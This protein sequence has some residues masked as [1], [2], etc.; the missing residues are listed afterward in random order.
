M[1]DLPSHK[2]QKSPNLLLKRRTERAE[3][4]LQA[5]IKIS[6]T[7]ALTHDKKQLLKLIMDTVTDLM[8][9]DRST[10]FL[11]DHENQEIVSQVIQG[12][13]SVH[14]R[15]PIGQ[16]VA[17]WVAQTGETVNLIDAY[18]DPRFHVKVDQKTG[19]TTRSILTMPL[20][21]LQ[22]H[23]IA[24]IQVLNKSSG[25][26]FSEEDEQLLEA[27]S[28]QAAIFLEN[29][30]LYS[31]LLQ[32][33]RELSDT[34][35]A[36]QQRNYELDILFSIEQQMSGAFEL[37]EMLSNILQRSTELLHCE[38]GLIGLIDKDKQLRLH[39][40]QAEK[41]NELKGRVLKQSEGFMGW[42]A[43][44]GQHI[45]SNNPIEDN[46]FKADFAHQ[47]GLSVRGVLCVPLL[48]G[49]TAIGAIE[50][51]NKR[52]G[53]E[54]FGD[55]DLRILSLIAARVS[56]A[57]IIGLERNKRMRQSRLATIG[58]LLSGVVH[59]FKTPMTLIAGYAQLT[60]NQEDPEKRKTFA[61]MIQ[62]Q[63]DRLNHMT[64]EVL[65]F[66]R[67]ESTLLVRKVHLNQFAQE[68]KQHLE[69]EFAHVP[70]QLEFQTS[71]TGD[72]YFDESKIERLLH[73]LARNA[74]QAMPNGGTFA[75]RIQLEDEQLVIYAQDTGVGIPLE[76]QS[77]IFDSFVTGRPN[78]GT[79]LG[80]AIVK[81]IVKEHQGQISFTS[82]PGKGTTFRVSLPLH[83]PSA[84][85]APQTP[86]PDAPM[87]APAPA[88]ETPIF[89][90]KAPLV[91]SR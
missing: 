20:R 66:A 77:K 71:Y 45:L 59:D 87:L 28:A 23:T 17:G 51:I 84:S 85:T 48:N 14:I 22:G 73:N 7:L 70:I 42:S 55:S 49:D 19:Y 56:R 36:L 38:A 91:Q 53:R 29:A 68:L 61:D 27:I 24:V 88:N 6:R 15:M 78:Q 64:R 4:Q 25:L 32:K 21:T 39:S 1:F 40:I 63:I 72:A 2:G 8:E 9:A 76:L 52:N 13:E 86:N 62:K 43:R 34:S 79:G 75:L 18:K 31:T 90:E 44:Y 67:G 35:R 10:L 89:Q 47:L 26:A 58:K 65:A 80:L 5:V 74:I 30:G 3:K 12:E 69:Q 46:R 81:K 50:L 57:V 33:N 11:I 37:D 16:G 83:G 54:N 60:A 41:S 82:E